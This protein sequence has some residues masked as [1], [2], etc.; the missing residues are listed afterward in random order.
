MTKHLTV[1]DTNVFVSGL[2][3]PGGTPARI[4]NT[5]VSGDTIPVADS[6]ILAE[7]FD[8]LTRAKFALPQPVVHTLAKALREFF[9]PV[10]P[11]PL[12]R[13]LLL[14]DRDDEKFLA[15]AIS[16]GNIP[17]VTGNM[18]HFDPTLLTAAGLNVPV[19]TPE[20]YLRLRNLR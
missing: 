19:L 15:V 6:L 10:T 20:D 13:S 9:L 16:A 8:V 3:S 2:L 17:L 18:R 4:I 1:I 12:P 7:Y 11:A 5:I 14:P